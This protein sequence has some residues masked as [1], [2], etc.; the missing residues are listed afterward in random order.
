MG[1]KSRPSVITMSSVIM[2]EYER[3]R[4]SEFEFRK[5]ENEFNTMEKRMNDRSKWIGRAE[6]TNLIKEVYSTGNENNKHGKLTPSVDQ[7]L[8]AK[9]QRNVRKTAFNTRAPSRT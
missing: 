8:Q 6:K 3:V 5:T 2:R 7:W 4:K 9:K 1:S